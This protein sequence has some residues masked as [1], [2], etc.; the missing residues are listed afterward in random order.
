MPRSTK[1]IVA[2]V[3]NYTGALFRGIPDPAD[4]Q[5]CVLTL[6][7]TDEAVVAYLRNNCG[8][9]NDEPLSLP[10]YIT[11]LK[12]GHEPVCDG[13]GGVYKISRGRKEL[14]KDE[15]YDEYKRELRSALRFSV[16]AGSASGHNHLNCLVREA[17]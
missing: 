8:Y 11:A 14:Y 13:C 12:S 4:D 9:G 15:N 16:D 2:V 10:D 7:G 1:P 6:T 5:F 17:V 3:S